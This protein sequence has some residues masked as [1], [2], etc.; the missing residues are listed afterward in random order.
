M[1]EP[2]G[3]RPGSPSLIPPHA[4]KT[5]PLRRLL[6]VDD[7]HDFAQSL[8][9]LLQASGYEVRISFDGPSALVMMRL[10]A[11]E[12][13]LLDIGLPGMDGYEVARNVRGDAALEPRLLVAMSG[14]EPDEGRPRHPDLAFDHFLVKPIDLSH[15]LA[16]LGSAD[17]GASRD[18][19]RPRQPG[20]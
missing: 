3:D 18:E 15:L 6:L 13:V 11:P 1:N 17:G 5:S 8:A 16:V 12:V 7:N 4:A 2:H 9:R 14:Y 19:F 10:F 20:P